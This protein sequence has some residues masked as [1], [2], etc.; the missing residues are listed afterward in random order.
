MERMRLSRFVEMAIILRNFIFFPDAC[1][2][3]GGCGLEAFNSIINLPIM[4]VFQ[5]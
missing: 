3:G 1:P 2:N 5:I 4:I